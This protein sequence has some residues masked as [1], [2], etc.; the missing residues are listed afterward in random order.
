[1]ADLTEKEKDELKNLENLLNNLNLGTA[2]AAL[3]R[4][5]VGLMQRVSDLE[6]GSGSGD[7]VTWSTLSGKPDTFP[8]AIGNTASTALAGNTQLLKVG[9]GANDAKAGNYN[10]P[11]AS[12]SAPGIIQIG[13]GAGN[14]AAGDH[15]HA[16][17]AD[18]P[19]G[20]TAAA[21]LQALA[22]ALSARIKALEDAGP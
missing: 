1:M 20:L 6:G 15:G 11:S 13:T 3:G 18:V 14:A 12:T 10:P 9:T 4:I 17:T 8:P 16:I 22:V 2:K 21:N 19:S 5:F 7:P